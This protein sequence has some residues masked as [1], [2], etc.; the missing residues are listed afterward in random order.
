MVA[1]HAAAI[2]VSV[3]LTITGAFCLYGYHKKLWALV[4]VSTTFIVM[5]AIVLVGE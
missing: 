2:F 4:A 5:N 1:A 3:F